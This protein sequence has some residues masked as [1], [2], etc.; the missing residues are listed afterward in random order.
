MKN[1]RKIKAVFKNW[2][3]LFLVMSCPYFLCG[4][5]VE[6]RNINFSRGRTLSMITDMDQDD[7]GYIWMSTFS[8]GLLRYDGNSLEV[9]RFE[10][11][12]IG[13]VILE[14]VHVDASGKVWIGG[15]ENGLYMVDPLTKEQTHY[16]H[17]IDDEFSLGNNS[18][19]A[20]LEDSK[21]TFWIGT[22]KG[23]D[24][25]D[26]STGKFYRVNGNMKASDRLKEEHVRTIYE[27]SQH[28]TWIGCG[29]ATSPSD[30][31][32]LGGL[33]KI[34][35]KSKKIVKYSAAPED[36]DS[37]IN[38]N[39]RAVFEDSRGV[40]WVGT[41]GDGLHTFDR[42]S[43]KFTRYP[44]K[45]EN[46]LGLSRPSHD[47]EYIADHITFINEDAQGFI[48]IGTLD[49]GLNQY[50][51]EKDQITFY[52]PEQLGDSYLNRTDHWASLRTNDG[53]LWIS[54][55]WPNN[56]EANQRLLQ[57]STGLNNRSF[58]NPLDAYVLWL[59][60]DHNSTIWIGTNLGLYRRN[61]DGTHS[62]FKIN[63]LEYETD[64]DAVFYITSGPKDVLY[65]ATGEGIL[66]FDT[67]LEQFS[68]IKSEHDFT[69]GF[70]YDPEGILWAV[71]PEGFD[72]IDLST[73]E[74]THLHGD[75]NA[76]EIL[77]SNQVNWIIEGDQGYLWI[78]TDQGLLKYDKNLMSSK[79]ILE[80]ERFRTMSIDREGILWAVGAYSLFKLD[81]KDNSFSEIKDATQLIDN[82]N[83]ANV[84]MKLSDNGTLWLQKHN[85]LVNYNPT[86]G[87]AALRGAS[88][89]DPSLVLRQMSLNYTS[90]NE[91]LIGAGLGYFLFHEEILNQEQL[92]PTPFLSNLKTT[93][94]N[95]ALNVSANSEEREPINLSSSE[96]DIAFSFGNVDLNSFDLEENLQYKLENFDSEWRSAR[97]AQKVNFYG[98]PPGSYVFK[99]R[100]A[101]RYGL[102]SE[103]QQAI[104]ISAPWYQT[105]WAYLVY[106]LIFGG[107]IYAF[108]RFMRDRLIQREKEKSIRKELQQAKEIEKA[109]TE[110]KATQSQLIQS[111][112]MASLGE[113][114]AGIAHEIQNPLN[115]VNNFSQVSQEL[116]LE[117]HEELEKGDLTSAL[118]LGNDI[119]Q[120]L[121]KINHHG[122]RASEI[123]KGMLQHSRSSNGKK[124]LTNINTLADEYLRLAYHGLRAK[125]KSFNAT[126]KTDFDESIGE[127]N[128]VSQ[129]IG[130]VILNLITNAFYV[131]D[132]KKK[133]NLE[134]YKPT[135]SVHTEKLTDSIEISVRDNGNGIP[136]KVLD[137]IFQPFF[138]TKPAGEGTGL[139]LSLSYDIVKAHG[140]ELKV[141]TKEGEGTEFI[142]HL[143]LKKTNK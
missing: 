61:A 7:L 39:V 60:T 47:P 38:R 111:E 78:A 124:E 76:P 22:S 62:F 141:E 105:V 106:I 68:R 108:D 107:L 26:R 67:K 57:I 16:V 82:E 58:Y 44:Y 6:I 8:D 114:T 133:L 37:L 90:N 41:G 98:L 50:D 96:N 89:I 18:V 116:M 113:L 129:D 31:P 19:R 81:T 66:T 104:S 140:G 17:N 49:R 125:D 143:Q 5:N 119:E 97:N 10:N 74:V 72:K 51:P 52:G 112:K 42:K 9:I 131:V 14:T 34:D 126:I 48:W 122:Q 85:G 4:Q 75:T 12:S 99:V 46:P 27:D 102:I 2:K 94:R 24:T 118:E 80:N 70:H 54:D 142:I 28:T 21:G 79:M 32:E 55:A 101:N 93:D 56:S 29:D 88:W 20:I 130:R 100:A 92:S 115:F 117:M 110:L 137:K 132:E 134:N 43:D 127:I 11:S 91:I 86:T 36:P 35:T 71:S 69:F 121:E 73:E 3:L 30:D 139:G 25:L 83:F 45:P 135:V 53:S 40:F 23:L 84:G 136:K 77:A 109:Y 87:I 33:Y 120:N 65:L 1:L 64:K 59:E 15:R 103:V 123:V 63:D 128:I 13:S 95:I 138:T